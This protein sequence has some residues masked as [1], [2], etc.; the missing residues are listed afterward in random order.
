MVTFAEM[1]AAADAENLKAE[2][3]RKKPNPLIDIALGAAGGY[4]TG[5]LLPAVLGGAASLAPTAQTLL[6]ALQGGIQGASAKTPEEA[7]MGGVKAGAEPAIMKSMGLAPS[8]A[9]AG[10]VSYSRPASVRLKSPTKGAAGKPT[11]TTDQYQAAAA[12]YGEDTGRGADWGK[13]NFPKLKD[14]DQRIY[15][16]STK[17]VAT[18][19]S[20]APTSSDKIRVVGPDGQRGT[21]DAAE[22]SKWQSKGWKR[23]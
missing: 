21:M 18:T 2:Q 9:K 14:S 8:T 23:E 7:A 22:F 17:G 5:G 4:L 6:P 12:K 1:M 19:P 20:A 3:D 13:R 16:N 10:E 11:Y 15:L